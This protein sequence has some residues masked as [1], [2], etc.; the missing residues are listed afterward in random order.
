LTRITTGEKERSASSVRTEWKTA[1]D[2]AAAKIRHDG[3]RV[4]FK[5]QMASAYTDVVTNRKPFTPQ[6]I[7]KHYLDK[8][9]VDKDDKKLA[10]AAVAQRIAQNNQTL[11]RNVAGG[12]SPAP[13]R[14]PK[15]SMAEV[16]RR[17]QRLNG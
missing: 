12:G 14:N 10:N 15:P 8:L 2:A 11:P 9:G 5:D 3:V 7:I 13:A 1:I 16:R 6:Q 4:L 17:L